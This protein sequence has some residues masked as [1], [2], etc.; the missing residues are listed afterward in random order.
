MTWHIDLD[1]LCALPDCTVC[2]RQTCGDASTCTGELAALCER[3]QM[4]Q[5]VEAQER[6]V[7]GR[8][9]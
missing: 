6:R 7:G 1:A 3:I 9:A 5:T 8:V 2:G 4:R